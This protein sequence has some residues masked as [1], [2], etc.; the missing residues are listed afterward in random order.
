MEK[1][2][3]IFFLA[4]FNQGGAGKSIVN[5]CLNL[6]KKKYDISIICLNRCYYK[7]ILL[8]KNINVIEIN[9]KKVLFVGTELNR[10]IKFYSKKKNKIIFVSNLFYTNALVSLFIKRKKNTKIIFTERTPLQELFIYFGF[11]DLIKKLIIRNILRFNYKRANVI[12]A[13]SKKTANDINNF[14]DSKVAHIYPPS[15]KKFSINLKNKN[16]KIKVLN[17]L[18][19]GRLSVEKNFVFLIRA[20]QKLKNVN[21]V[22]KIVGNGPDRKKLEKL[23][24]QLNLQNKIEFLGFKKNIKNLLNKSDLLINTSKFEGFPNVVVEAISSGVP[25]ISSKSHGGI[26]EILKKKS[27]GMTY[28]KENE[29]SLIN[30]INYFIKKRYLFF[31]KK[32]EVKTAF[33]HFSAKFS[34]KRYESV[35]DKL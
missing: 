5:L 30:K 20:L 22:L 23:V 12:I 7:P 34:C 29:D 6:D 4:N 19:V 25:V 28:T 17:L 26:M 32:K 9:K 15:F 10:I 31:I 11:K 2:Q 33:K 24:T 3:I 8:K 21:F 27:F 35:F 14:S 1:K 13:N 18:A 16:R